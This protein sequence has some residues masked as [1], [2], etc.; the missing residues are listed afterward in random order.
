MNDSVQDGPIHRQITL[1]PMEKK[2]QISAYLR[3]GF[4][5]LSGVGMGGYG[6]EG[7]VKNGVRPLVL[8]G[9]PAKREGGEENDEHDVPEEQEEEYTAPSY[10]F[11]SLDAY[12]SSLPKLDPVNRTL[13]WVLYS[14]EGELGEIRD[15]E[16]LLLPKRGALEPRLIFTPALSRQETEVTSISRCESARGTNGR[17]TP[18]PR[19]E[20]QP[21]LDELFQRLQERQRK[22]LGG[23]LAHCGNLTYLHPVKNTS[24]RQSLEPLQVSP[25]LTPDVIPY[26]AAPLPSQ[27]HQH[28]HVDNSH[29]DS[30]TRNNTNTNNQLLPPKRKVSEEDLSV[31]RSK[32][33]TLPHYRS[34]S[35][36]LCTHTHIHTCMYSEHALNRSVLCF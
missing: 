33:K 18:P 22:V 1:P 14:D 28:E 16:L 23:H 36:C 5:R 6:N 32:L 21:R 26:V 17:G 31:N 12:L 30:K 34:V 9:L 3:K 29:A 11:T 20:D 27:H 13:V 2:T 25:E 19:D 35:D 24:R 4:R 10:E 15:E 8:D 7:V